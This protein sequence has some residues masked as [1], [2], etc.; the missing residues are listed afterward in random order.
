ML[1]CSL[2]S[3]RCTQRFKLLPCLCC[4]RYLILIFYKYICFISNMCH[5]WQPGGLRQTLRALCWFFTE[6]P[7]PAKPLWPPAHMPFYLNMWKLCWISASPKLLATAQDISE[8]KKSGLGGLINRAGWLPLQAQRE[9]C[10]FPKDFGALFPHV[11]KTR[12]TPQLSPHKFPYFKVQ[13]SVK[14]GRAAGGA[15]QPGKGP[16]RAASQGRRAEGGIQTATCFWGHKTCFYNDIFAIS[17]VIQDAGLSKTLSFPGPL[18][19]APRRM[20]LGQHHH[21]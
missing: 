4:L 16:Q 15:A 6:T 1:W 8:D 9:H 12:G 18:L 3:L 14:V 19:G 5:P 2:C 13:V 10:A 11:T 17:S 21:R 20:E 7:S